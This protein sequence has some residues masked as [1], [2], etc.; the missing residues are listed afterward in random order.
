MY[1]AMH[2]W[3]GRVHNGWDQGSDPSCH[4]FNV[5]LALENI[6]LRN[7]GVLGS[8]TNSI[9]IPVNGKLNPEFIWTAVNLV[10]FCAPNVKQTLQAFCIIYFSDSV[11][12]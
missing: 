3:L 9:S 7:F 5:S 2:V 6:C 11:C 8:Y 1:R 12:P 4:Y 10:L